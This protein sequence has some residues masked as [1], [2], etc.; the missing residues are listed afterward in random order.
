[1]SKLIAI[2]SVALVAMAFTGT[3]GA[4]PISQRRS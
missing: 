3:A 1:M 2:G 4:S